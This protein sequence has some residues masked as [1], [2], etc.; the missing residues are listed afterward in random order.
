MIQKLKDL[1]LPIAIAVGF[2]FHGFFSKLMPYTPWLIFAMLYFTLNSLDIKRVRVSMLH[3]SVLFFQ[4]IMGLVV[5]FIL[6]PVNS[7]LAQGAMVV[8][9]IPT[10]NSAAVVAA[11]LGADLSKM[12]TSTLLTNVAVAVIAPLYISFAGVQ[13]D[14]PF[15]QSVW[16]VLSKVAPMMIVPLI[17]ALL[18]R[19]FIPRL[20]KVFVKH[21]NI[22]FYLWA[23]SLT[24]VIGSTIDSISGMARSQTGIILWMALVSL[25]LCV[26]QFI[27]G[28]WVGKRFGDV[29][30]GGQSV[31]QKNTVLAIWMAQTYMAPITAVIPALYVLWQNLYNSYQIWQK[32]RREN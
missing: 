25:L 4:V 1:T 27:Y 7:I 26:V 11:M 20:A 3:V 29:V 28:R 32:R 14:L 30:A 19:R 18:T 9:I 12:V 21:K 5:Y 15:I 13:G 6:L 24:I 16:I 23:V 17:F 8:V 22:S 31:G 10:A 2:L